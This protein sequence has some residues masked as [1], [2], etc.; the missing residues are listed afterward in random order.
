MSETT[1][2]AGTM[3]AD[4]RSKQR[5]KQEVAAYV[6]DLTADLARLARGHGMDVL[7]HILDMARLEAGTL[8]LKFE[9]KASSSERRR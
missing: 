9:A 6:A 2:K 3:D 5:N 8:A 1:P 4:P 7:G